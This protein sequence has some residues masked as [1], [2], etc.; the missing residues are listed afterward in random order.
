MI[1]GLRFVRPN[2]TFVRPDGT[3]VTPDGTF[4]RPDKTFVIT[5]GRMEEACKFSNCLL[6]TRKGYIH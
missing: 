6:I 2:G 3:F 5:L 4:V 1:A